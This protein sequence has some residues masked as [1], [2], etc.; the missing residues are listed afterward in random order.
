VEGPNTPA[1]ERAIYAHTPANPDMDDLEV[2]LNTHPLMLL[3]PLIPHG[4]VLSYRE[5]RH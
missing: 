3:N 5:L 1:I 2:R 4:C